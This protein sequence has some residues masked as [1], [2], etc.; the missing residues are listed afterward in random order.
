MRVPA[1]IGVL[2]VLIGMASC[3]HVPHFPENGLQPIRETEDFA[4]LVGSSDYPVGT[5]IR[6]AGRI[7]RTEEKPWGFLL[8]ADWLPYPQ[9]TFVGPIRPSPTTEARFFLRYVGPIDEDGRYRG[10]EFMA[11]GALLE[12][13]EYFT[14]QGILRKVPF[15][16]AECLHVWKTAGTPLEEFANMDAL[17]DRYP[18]PLE[19]TYCLKR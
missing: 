18:P 8:L 2:I 10:N 17:D 1:C 7:V 16:K 3:H 11:F 14:A 15:V 19:E 5:R 9:D 4:Q 12:P 13:H 6:L